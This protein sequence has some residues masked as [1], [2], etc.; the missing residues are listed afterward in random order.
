[1]VYV[2][3]DMCACGMCVEVCM[4]VWMCVS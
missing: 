1:V 2:C 3:V 4:H